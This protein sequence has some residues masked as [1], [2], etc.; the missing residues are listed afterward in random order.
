MFVML[1]MTFKVNFYA[2]CCHIIKYQQ[3]LLT[4]SMFLALNI[5]CIVIWF[6]KVTATD[7]K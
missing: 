3:M 5:F 2:K 1:G 4:A 7:R 6:N